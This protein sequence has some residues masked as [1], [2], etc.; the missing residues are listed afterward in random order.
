MSPRKQ[1]PVAK[2]IPIDRK[3]LR[4]WPLPELDGELG[5]EERGQVLVIGGSTRV[6]GAVM[7]AAAAALRAG[8]GRLQIATSRSVA[9]HVAVAMPE[10]CVWPLRESRDGEP[11]PTCHR[12]I[13]EQIAR[14]D[15]LLVGPGMSD[16][17]LGAG[18]LRECAGAKSHAAFIVDGAALSALRDAPHLL[19]EHRA[20]A[21]LTP[22]AGEMAKMCGISREA[23]LRDPLALAAAQARRLNAVLVLKGSVTRVACPD[24]TTYESTNGNLGLGTSGSGDTLAGIIAGLCARGARPDQAAVWG[25]FLHA[26]AGDVLAGAMGGM[27]FLARELPRQIPALLDDLSSRAR[28]RR[29]GTR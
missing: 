16:S 1:A 7:L 24:G 3:L 21:V 20:G 29:P 19:A 2:P 5:K 14:A 6:P 18:L 10:A 9:P 15:A 23:V 26:S 11:A 8:A 27:G 12:D 25:V 28:K 17:R 4:R 13:L 22:H